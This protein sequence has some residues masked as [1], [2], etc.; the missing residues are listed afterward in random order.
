M[1]DIGQGDSLLIKTPQNKYILVDGGDNFDSDYYVFNIVPKFNCSLDLIIL[2]HPHKDHLLGINRL[3]QHCNIKEVI[4][5]SIEYKSYIFDDFKQLLNEKNIFSKAV[6]EGD[7]YSIND[8]K[9][10]FIWPSFEY[11]QNKNYKTNI[12][13][14]SISFL[15]DYGDIEALF[16]GDAEIT[17]QKYFDISSIKQYI[18][19]NKLEFY[20]VAHHGSINGTLNAL[21][22]DLNPELLGISVGKGNKFNHPSPDVIEFFEKNN[23]PYFRTDLMDTLKLSF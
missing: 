3:L 16:L 5:E 18:Q 15:L 17:A 19:D 13:D 1:L 9:L 20:K 7:T 22:L 6:Y 14:T 2:T 11:I 12:N 8:I 21:V 4:Y 10:Y 23:F